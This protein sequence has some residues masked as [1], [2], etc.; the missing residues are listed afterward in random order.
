MK[1]QRGITLVE[2]A[3]SLVIL[4]LLGVLVAQVLGYSARQRE[5][6]AE[7]DLLARADDAVTGFVSARHRLP[8]PDLDG[9]G[10]EDCMSP[11]AQVGHLA[12][13]SI[14]LPDARAA[15]LRYGVLRR[16]AA[17]GMLDADLAEA[18]QRFLPLTTTP[19]M[20]RAPGAN[21]LD[22]CQATR[23]AAGQAFDPAFLHTGNGNEAR[24]VAY[25]L[26]APGV[27][28][29]NGDGNP[30]DG[31]QALVEARFERPQRGSA[32]DYDDRVLAVGFDQLWARLGC[33]EALAAAGHAHYNAAIA[34]ALLRQGAHDYL[35]LL[36]LA[37][38]MGE[39]TVSSAAASLLGATAGLATAT[40]TTLIAT[41]EALLSLGTASGLV[42]LAVAAVA[43]NTAAIVSAGVAVGLAQVSL[44]RVR[45]RIADGERVA[46]AADVL[47]PEIAT[48]AKAALAAGLY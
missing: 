2:L 46:A 21:A 22:L 14:G 43:A 16:P 48:N 47:A 37:E 25:A 13:R 20:L 40:S 18:R 36:K 42:G 29:A 4:G 32:P 35:K 33:G 1:R 17:D 39:A 30:F 41:A 12:W 28:D 5:A 19:E 7:R 10:R 26:A 11:I 15:R 23:V 34:A 38:K 44:D 27:L 24:H 6:L 9:D 8:C 45:A 3:L 31:A